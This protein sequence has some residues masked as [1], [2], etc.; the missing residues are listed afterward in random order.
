MK[1]SSSE[2]WELWYLT[3]IIKWHRLESLGKEVSVSDPVD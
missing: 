1:A 3:L 2:N